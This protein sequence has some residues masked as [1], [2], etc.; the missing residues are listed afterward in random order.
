M[1]AI[2]YLR[3]IWKSSGIVKWLFD[4]KG[5]LTS[6]PVRLIDIAQWLVIIVNSIDVFIHRG[7]WEDYG[8]VI[9]QIYNRRVAP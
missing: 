1:C 2:V 8:G 9:K 5:E 3:V 4:E 6:L 7:Y